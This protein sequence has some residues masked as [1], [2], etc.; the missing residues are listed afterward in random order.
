MKRSLDVANGVGMGVGRGLV[1]N[2]VL[3]EAVYPQKRVNVAADGGVRISM[4]GRVPNGA[5]FSNQPLNL[6]LPYAIQPGKYGPLLIDSHIR[7]TKIDQAEHRLQNIAC[8]SLQELLRGDIDVCYQFNYMLDLG[9]FMANVPP[10][11]LCA[12]F[13]FVVHKDPSLMQQAKEFNMG[14]H[15][16][17][18]MIIFYKDETARVVIHTANLVQ[19]DWGKKTQ[20]VWT[21]DLLKKKER[22]DGSGEGFAQAVRSGQ[23][24]TSD[25]EHDLLSYLNSYG[26]ELQ[27]L[28]ERLRQFDFSGVNVSLV[29]SVPGRHRLADNKLKLWGHPRLGH[30][31]SELDL[32]D[33]CQQDSSLII[34]FS[35]IGSLGKD[36]KWLLHEFA[37]SLGK[38]KSKPAQAKP[39]LKIVYPTVDEVRDSDFER[40]DLSLILN[41]NSLHKVIKRKSLTS[42]PAAKVTIRNFTAPDLEGAV[43]LNGTIT[44]GIEGIQEAVIPVQL[45]YDIPL[46]PY[47]A[48]DDPWR[49]DVPFEG[50]DSLGELC[51]REQ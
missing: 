1:A 9:F 3:Q 36:N 43:L 33:G 24:I 38:T 5:Q 19:K 46:T 12:T 28:R 45:P 29:A 31:L 48:G 30:L 42:S 25:F 18:A 21:S 40:T 50:Y 51:L 23:Y 37:S 20:G 35:S 8:T 13:H 10:N 14:T 22:P 44:A 41:P 39:P 11:N 27:A 7:L 49:W 4:D 34:Q 2:P 17:K 15:H 6:S 47:K 32:S 26:K 16:S